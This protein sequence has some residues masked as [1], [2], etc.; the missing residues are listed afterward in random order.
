MAISGLR[1]GQGIADKEHRPQ[2]CIPT[3]FKQGG[4]NCYIR[5]CWVEI[6]RVTGLRAHKNRGLCQVLLDCYECPI[7]FLIPF[8]PVGSPQG[9]EEGFQ[10]VREPGNKTPKSSQSAGQLLDPFFGGGSRGLQDGL[11]LCRISLCSSLGYHK[12][13]ESVGAD[14]EGTF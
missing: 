1:C 6:D 2:L 14:P 7:A 3:F 13:K 4:A 12:T 5:G 10:T 9:S 11:N 8:G